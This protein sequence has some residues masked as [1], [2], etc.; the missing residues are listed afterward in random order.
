MHNVGN[1][2][3]FETDLLKTMQ[4]QIAITIVTLFLISGCV[5]NTPRNISNLPADE[6]HKVTTKK[7]CQTFINPDINNDSFDGSAI[8]NELVNRNVHIPVLNACITMTAS[9]YTPDQICSGYNLAF[10]QDQETVKVGHDKFKTEQLQIYI[11]NNDIKCLT[12][13]EVVR[14]KA[15]WS[16]VGE[17][18]VDTLESL[19]YY[20]R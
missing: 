12:A 7:L 1:L 17:I 2:P 4:K 18:I 20:P 16:E 9:S 5:V 13:Y 10:Y 14:T 19:Q 8:Y 15:F 6:L 11:K 3:F